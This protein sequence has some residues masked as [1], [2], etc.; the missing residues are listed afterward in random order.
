MVPTKHI[1]IGSSEIEPERLESNKKED[2]AEV[3]ETVESVNLGLNVIDENADLLGVGEASDEEHAGKESYAGSAPSTTSKQK[4]AKVYVPP[5]IDEMI[6]QTVVAID[7]LIYQSIEQHKKLVNNKNAK[8]IH[9]NVLIIKIRKLKD[10]KFQLENA[11]HLAK[12]FIV[13]MWNQ[14]VKRA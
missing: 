6:A 13:N 8:P 7:H 10:L 9:L 2:S 11:T 3:L 5:T 14:Y 12:E 1:N 4:Q